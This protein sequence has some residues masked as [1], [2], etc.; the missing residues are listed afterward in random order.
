MAS[1]SASASENPSS[2]S[3]CAIVKNSGSVTFTQSSRR[4]A[5]HGRR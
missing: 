2:A 5:H 3:S 1:N 4:R